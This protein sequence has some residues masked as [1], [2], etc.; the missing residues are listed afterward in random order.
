MKAWRTALGI[1]AALLLG[2]HLASD[3]FLWFP[4]PDADM[5]SFSEAIVRLRSNHRGSAPVA[6]CLGSSRMRHGLVPE[7][8][9]E[10]FGL[11]RG[12]VQNYG[13]DVGTPWMALKFLER[14]ELLEGSVKVIF[15]DLE[16]WQFNAAFPP[17]DVDRQIFYRLASLGEKIASGGVRQKA[18]FLADALV[19]FVSENRPLELWAEGIR[20]LAS[21]GAVRSLE[22]P[23]AWRRRKPGLDERFS[24]EEAARRHM[25]G[26]RV[27]RRVRR[28]LFDL[29]AR[30]EAKKISLVM[31]QMPV[32]NRY[33]DA[34]EN[35][36]R[37]ASAYADYLKWARSLSRPERRVW[38]MVWER[39]EEL[40][41]DDKAFLDYGHFT[42]QG[43]RTFTEKFIAHLPE[44]VL[45]A[46]RGSA[47]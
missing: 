12:A 35:D 32:S 46:L 17:N 20:Y 44:Q 25:A 27:D 11:A 26:Y 30:V 28:A 34:I 8:M 37:F 7:V 41:L 19:P 42:R 10:A 23:H 31:F 18:F 14:T 3:A 21:D 4:G 6:L 45:D 36:E 15:L 24:P 13:M 40:G 5:A 22:I 43:A 38:A 47:G 16:P 1:V 39:P 9:E 2:Y 29:V 33:L